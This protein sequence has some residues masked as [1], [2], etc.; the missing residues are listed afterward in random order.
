MPYSSKGN[1]WFPKEISPPSNC[2]TVTRTRIT[3]TRHGIVRE[4]ITYPLS[5]KEK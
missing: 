4:L 3:Y 1:V 2:K 5:L